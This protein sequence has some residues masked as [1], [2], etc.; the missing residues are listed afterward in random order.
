MW[1]SMGVVLHLKHTCK[2]NSNLYSC[3][4]QTF[5]GGQL[6]S[7]WKLFIKI[8]CPLL[9]P[10]LQNSQESLTPYPKRMFSVSWLPLSFQLLEP[11]HVFSEPCS[12][13]RTVVLLSPFYP[14]GR[15]K[16]SGHYLKA[17]WKPLRGRKSNKLFIPYVNNFNLVTNTRE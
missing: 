5:K 7:S 10:V 15:K 4:S 2:R 6:L 11:N 13:L 3:F 16:K 1:F 17:L 9:S 8:P 14:K 12:P